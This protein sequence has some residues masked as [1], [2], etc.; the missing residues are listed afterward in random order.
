MNS[1]SHGFLFLCGLA[2][3]LGEVCV[4]AGDGFWGPL[5]LYLLGLTV[6]FSLMGCVKVSDKTINAAGPVFTGIMG[7]SIILY[8]FG[9][10]SD[11]ALGGLFR[12]V[13]GTALLYLAFNSFLS[14][15]KGEH[16][17]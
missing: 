11:S 14:R 9:A 7:A 2:W 1:L 13:L 4:S 16:A 3:L 17:H 15:E 8:A 6:M 12:L 5:W 10:F